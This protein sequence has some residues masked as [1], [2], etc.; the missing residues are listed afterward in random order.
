MQQQA[1]ALPFKDQTLHGDHWIGR[2]QVISAE[3]D[4]VVPTAIPARYAREALAAASCHHHVIADAG[5]DLSA[6]FALHPPARV[7]A[8]D[9]LASLIRGTIA[10]IPS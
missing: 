3:H 4:A 2:L 10:P 9:L 6:H 5:H 1:F 7:R 8:Y